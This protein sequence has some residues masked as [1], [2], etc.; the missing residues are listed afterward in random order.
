MADGR[1]AAVYAFP[2]AGWASLELKALNKT[3]RDARLAAHPYRGDGSGR[4]EYLYAHQSCRAR[5]VWAIAEY[6]Q[7]ESADA[8]N[9][10]M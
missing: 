1:P 6:H 3:K 4:V 5:N 8:W 7:I 2:A 9:Y 10:H